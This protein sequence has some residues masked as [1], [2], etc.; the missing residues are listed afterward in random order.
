MTKT[1]GITREN[2]VDIDLIEN[3]TKVV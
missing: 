1:D 3:K 2:K